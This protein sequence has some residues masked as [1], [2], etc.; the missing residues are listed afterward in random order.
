MHAGLFDM[1][2]D[3]GNMHMRAVAKRVHI[4]L[5]RT[6]EVAVEQHRTIAR[7][8]NGFR[9]IAFKIGLIADNFHRATAQDI[10]RAN[11]QRETDF[12]RHCQSFS[13]RMGNAI[14]GLFE[15][16]GID[17]LLEAFAVF[18]Q[19]DCIGCGAQDWDA[20]FLEGI[21]QLQRCLPAELH[22]HTMQRAVLLLDTQ[23]F[24]HMLIGQRLKIQAV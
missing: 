6:R 2:H 16:E 3:A 5:N 1:L 15:L 8:H 17:Q 12:G 10:G 24:H 18:G 22:N 19:V 4:N 20:C 14:L 13:V 21:G 11:D 23:D 9:N 7:D